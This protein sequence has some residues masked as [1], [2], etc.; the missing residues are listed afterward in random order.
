MADEDIAVLLVDDEPDVA[1]VTSEFIEHEEPRIQVEMVGTA[2]AGL[3]RLADGDV[4][5]IV[6]DF[7]MPGRDGIEF[8][9]TVR[10]RGY[11]HPFILFTGKGS[12]EVAADAIS[13]GA[14]D[15]L[16]KAPGNEQYT[17]LA[18]RIAQAVERRRADAAADAANERLATVFDRV[19]D[20]VL[21]MD[22]SFRYT[23]VNAEAERLL[24]LDAAAMVG[25]EAWEV[26]PELDDTAFGPALRRAMAEQ[27]PETVEEY[28]PPL[29]TWYHVRIYPAEDGLSV[30]FRDISDRKSREREL[31][32]ERE[33]YRQLVESAPVGI[34]GYDADETIVYAN[35]AAARLAGVSE[36]AALEGRSPSSSSTRTT[37][38][39]PGPGWRPSS[40]RVGSTSRS[41]TG[42]SART[43]SSGTSRS[44]PRP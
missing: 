16:Q 15:Y 28:W 40:P 9:E 26:F 21:A 42:W 34:L 43:T 32:N 44:R 36:P 3:E 29:D 22:S 2:E 35:E 27:Q 18:N 38:R 37:A 41:S 31:A 24:D 4:D 5:C 19:T 8:L 30:Y 17:I 12:E 33:R 10:E 11:D 13:A 23:Y 20:A 1:G 39:P 7:E 14:T 25:R 6:S